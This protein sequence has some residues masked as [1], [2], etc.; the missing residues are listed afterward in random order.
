MTAVPASALSDFDGRLAVELACQISSLPDILKRYRLTRGDLK[1][2]LKDPTFRKMVVESKRA[3]HSD[4]SVKE[5]VRLKA[6]VLVE[7]S[8]L[9]VYNILH[10]SENP[11]ASRLDAFKQLARVA[12]VDAPGKS[13]MEAGEKFTVVINLG[14]EKLVIDGDPQPALE[15]PTL[16]SD[17]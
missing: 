13:T 8:I 7:D 17:E 4:L 10:D 12:D 5:R 14:D 9:A 15:V 3:W 6:S 2:K 16:T 1:V 11:S